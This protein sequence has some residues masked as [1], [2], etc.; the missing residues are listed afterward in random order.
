MSIE[1]IKPEV[2]RFF[3][4]EEVKVLIIKGRWGFGKTRFWRDMVKENSSITSS[5]SYSYVSLFGLNSIRDLQRSIFESCISL[6]TAEKSQNLLIEKYQQVSKKIKYQINQ[7]GG[8]LLK[9]ASSYI[10]DIS[11]VYESIMFSLVKNAIICLD[12]LERVGDN[13]QLKDI[14]GLISNL[15]EEANCKIVLIFNEDSLDVSHRI[16]YAK[17]REKIIDKELYFNPTFEENNRHVFVAS[18]QNEL[19]YHE[20]IEKCSFLKIKNIR[21]LLRIK[22]IFDRFFESIS[23]KNISPEFIKHL[24]DKIVFYVWCFYDSENNHGLNIREIPGILDGR[25]I[26]N[27]SDDQTAEEDKKLQKLIDFGLNSIDEIDGIIVNFLENGLLDERAINESYP[28]ICTKLRHIK[29]KGSIQDVYN[30]WLHS[31]GKDDQLLIKLIKDRVKNGLQYWERN[32]FFS[33]ISIL[34]NLEEEELTKEIIDTYSAINQNNPEVFEL[35]TVFHGE[36]IPKNQYLRDVFAQHYK[37]LQSAPKIEEILLDIINNQNFRREYIT[38]LEEVRDVEFYDFIT[39]IRT[40]NLHQ[41]LKYLVARTEDSSKILLVL[42]GVF[43]KISSE[44]KRNKV[45]LQS[46]LKLIETRLERNNKVIV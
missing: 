39:T 40:P 15:K 41:G 16:A 9:I 24:S 11:P 25:N 1:E 36:N 21:I 20:L 18:K 38:L 26:F 14:L 4:S 10:G 7:K 23:D 32:D 12:D 27:N 37:D 35:S 8:S 31:L 19:F 3:S 30:L 13:L 28:P 17:Y 33:I 45:M 5:K 44:S 22:N 6:E 2:N 29:E 43:E 34:E 42:K 46:L